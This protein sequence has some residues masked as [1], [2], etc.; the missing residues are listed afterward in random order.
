[1]SEYIYVCVCVC[2]CECVRKVGRRE[3]GGDDVSYGFKQTS[4]TGREERNKDV[5]TVGTK[6]KEGN[7]SKVGGAISPTDIFELV[8]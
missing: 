7:S 5:S 1:M 6:R 3:G 8:V 4:K 2:V